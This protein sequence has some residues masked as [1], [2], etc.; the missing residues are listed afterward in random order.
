MNPPDDDRFKAEF[1]QSALHPER[2]AAAAAAASAITTTT[3][4]AAIRAQSDSDAIGLV[5][6]L[7]AFIPRPGS[8]SVPSTITSHQSSSATPS[9]PPHHSVQLPIPTPTK[10]TRFL[11]YAEANLGVQNAPALEL[12]LK[13]KGYGPDILHLVEDSKLCSLGMSPGDVL[14]LKRG[15]P[16]WYSSPNAKRPRVDDGDQAAGLTS[17][18][19]VSI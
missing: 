9:T 1:R 16:E 4:T 8:G 7:L 14:R 5:K 13:M 15:A 18:A 11:A 19:H 17:G 6:E 12:S 2:Q 3:T 10:L